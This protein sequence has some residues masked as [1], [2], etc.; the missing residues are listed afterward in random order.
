MKQINFIALLFSCILFQ[1]C[2]KSTFSA[3]QI[4]GTWEL[5]QIQAGMSPTRD[6]TPGEEQIILTASTYEIVKNGTPTESGNYSVIED[7][8]VSKEVCLELEKGTY[9]HRIQFEGG[10]NSRKI[11]FQIKGDSMNTL[12]GCFALDGGVSKSYKKEF[13]H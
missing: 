2:D 11:F 7:P 6:A 4:K 10:D 5:V 8:S 9:T 12:S 13:I 3:D 1:S